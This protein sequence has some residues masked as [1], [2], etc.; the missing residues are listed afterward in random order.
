LGLK[1]IRPAKKIR[2]RKRI[3]N[4]ELVNKSKYLGVT[5][6]SGS[7]SNLDGVVLVAC[8]SLT[9]SSSYILA[10]R[11]RNPLTLVFT[12]VSTRLKT[13]ADTKDHKFLRATLREEM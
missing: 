2:L 4:L 13:V 8:S 11:F 7:V 9:D 5:S 6:L 1:I 10:Q 12:A 3:T